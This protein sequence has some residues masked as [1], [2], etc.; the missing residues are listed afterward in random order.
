MRLRLLASSWLACSLLL[1]P[2]QAE[3]TD[4]DRAAARSLGLEGQ[5]VLKDGQ[6]K[7]ALDLFQR[8]DALYHAPTLLL[9]IA[10]AQVGLGHLVS[11]RETYLRI[12][13]EGLP[14]KPSEAFR[15]AVADAEQELSVLEPRVPFLVLKLSD[16]PD[17]HIS[18]DDQ[19]FPLAALGVRRPLGPG[20]H[21]LSAKA[22]GRKDVAMEFSLREGEVREIEL[23]LEALPQPTASASAVVSSPPA[24]APPLVVA[25]APRMPGEPPDSGWMRP[26]GWVG[27][28]LGGVGFV[29]GSIWGLLAIERKST[30]DDACGGRPCPSSASSL[31][32][33]YERAGNIST[34]GFGVA[35]LGFGAGLPLLLLAPPRPSTAASPCV[36]HGHLG[37]CGR[38]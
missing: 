33:S 6:F 28:G 25:S 30:L 7:A 26:A 34:A 35:L 24:A 3:P 32:G 9:G 15:R 36:F 37:V 38:M 12:L 13:R 29:V 8:A 18:L 21:R 2:A 20:Q 27:V 16:A 23:R 4:A 17:V 11:A 14:S 1:T 31:R 22:P 19:E 5:R 10:R